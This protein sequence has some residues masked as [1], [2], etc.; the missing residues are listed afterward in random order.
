MADLTIDSV[1]SNDLNDEFFSAY[2]KKLAET[3]SNKGKT[4]TPKEYENMECAGLE[5]GHY[6]IVRCIGAPPDAEITGYKRRPHDAKEVYLITVRDDEGK[7]FNIRVPAPEVE[8]SFSHILHRLYSKVTESTYVNKKRIFKYEEKFPD[9]WAAVTKTGYK[10]ED[11][12]M[13]SFATG[14]K[15]TKLIVMNVIDREDDW[16]EQNKHTKILARS[17]SVDS[18]GTVWSEDGVKAYGFIGPVGDVIAKY[19]SFEKYDIAIKKTGQKDRPMEVK[20][21]SL[22]KEK[23]LLTEL[24]N[25]DG[26]VPPEDV[27]KIGPLTEE[28][29]KYEVYDLDR[30]YRPTSYSKILKRIPSVFKLCDAYLGTNFYEELKGL[31]EKEVEEMKKLSAEQT[32]A[33][34]KA[35]T[36]AINEN[37]TSTRRTFEESPVG[38]NSAMTTDFSTVL[39][40]YNLLTPEQKALIKN[41]NI[42]NGNVE[43]E[44]SSGDLKLLKCDDCGTPSPESFSCCPTCGLLFVE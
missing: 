20:N 12:K 21:A 35:E 9:L 39:K 29:R 41:V 31:A 10:P 36:A 2:S 44:W 37:L 3:N 4:F 14:L 6:R 24:L 13:F 5:T 32:A 11:G 28:E 42:E 40:G 33:Q 30:F 43:I 27:I 23:G 19:G 8:K 38:N 16:C 18:N 22:F 34:E 26:S 17:V 15:P 7:K 25:A 1:Q